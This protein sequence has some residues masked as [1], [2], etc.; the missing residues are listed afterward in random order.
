MFF[1][2]SRVV[3]MHNRVSE[4]LGQIPKVRKPHRSRQEHKEERK[5]VFQGSS[6]GKP[7]QNK[8]DSLAELGLE[9]KIDI[10]LVVGTKRGVHD[11]Y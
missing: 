10:N 11:P 8:T 3:L 4:P 2:A 7:K 6:R 9:L 1:K 5:L